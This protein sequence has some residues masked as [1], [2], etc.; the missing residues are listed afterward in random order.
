MAMKGKPAK[1]ERLYH[2]PP[3]F[4]FCCCIGS[5]RTGVMEW[6]HLRGTLHYYIH[7]IIRYIMEHTW[8]EGSTVSSPSMIIVPLDYR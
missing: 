7:I 4:I 3:E 1:C 5:E 2:G 8:R 6:E